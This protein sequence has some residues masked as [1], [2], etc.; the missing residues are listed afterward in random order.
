MLVEIEDVLGKVSRGQLAVPPG[1]TLGRMFDESDKLKRFGDSVECVLVD[2]MP[3]PRW[4]DLA[5]QHGQR[6]RFI[7]RPSDFGLISFIISAISIVTFFIS[8]F[9]RPQLRKQE[10]GSPTFTFEGI[11]DVLAP[12]D[13]VPVVYGRHRKGGQVLMYYIDTDED[14]KGQS[15][16]L[17][18]GMC[19]GEIDSIESQSIL[20]NGLLIDDISS[21][22]I[23]TRAGLSSQSII[24]GFESTKNTYFD[25]REVP[26]REVGVDV[27]SDGIVYRSVASAR[28]LATMEVQ[29]L[30]PD[31]IWNLDT[32]GDD[33]GSTS[34]NHITYEVNW[35]GVA[36]DFRPFPTNIWNTA[37][38]NKTTRKLTAKT[39]EK[40]IET[41]TLELGDTSGS[42]EIDHIYRSS[43]LTASSPLF[44]A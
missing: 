37:F 25:G 35:I 30:F 1:L 12:G 44:S 42:Q 38:G 34:N 29:L 17:L 5:P 16:S 33:A 40:Y 39:R 8:L 22:T 18:L 26:P 11:S 7:V 24:P 21:F 31:G 32:T 41:V 15:M 36:D 13:P 4:R 14:Q 2:G 28:D 27:W 6:V 19:E 20:I 10:G 43:L 9:N 3:A 23:D